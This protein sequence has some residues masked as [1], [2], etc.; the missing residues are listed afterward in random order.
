MSKN[1]YP[2]MKK[3]IKRYKPNESITFKIDPIKECMNVI[4]N[5][6]QAIMSV[7]PPLTWVNIKRNIDAI[8]NNIE[9]ECMIC[10]NEM[11]K[12]IRCNKCAQRYCGNCYLDI[13][14]TNRGIIICPYCRYEVGIKV[15]EDMLEI[16]IKEIEQTLG[17]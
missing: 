9:K 1:Y 14:K 12:S 8:F 17:Y 2:I 13:F 16:G 5:N 3:L 6:K 7:Y 15:S 10:N 4:F 11:F